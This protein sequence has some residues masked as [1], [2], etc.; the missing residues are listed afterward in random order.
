CVARKSRHAGTVTGGPWSPPI[1]STAMTVFMGESRRAGKARGASVL[2]LD[3]FPAAVVARRRD[4]VA[5]VRLA[6]GGL[7]RGRGF[8]QVV[9]RPVHAALRRRLLVLLNGHEFLLWR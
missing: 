2:G 8:A 6:R 3:H 4:V 7:H 5:K 1:A 9:V